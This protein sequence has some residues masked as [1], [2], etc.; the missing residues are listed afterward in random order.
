MAIIAPIM[1]TMLSSQDT[2]MFNMMQG[3]VGILNILIDI[4]TY[5]A[6]AIAFTLAYYDILARREGIPPEPGPQEELPS[7]GDLYRDANHVQA[8]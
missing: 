1:F 7:P 8:S 3:A 2:S 5:P 4:I 6:Y